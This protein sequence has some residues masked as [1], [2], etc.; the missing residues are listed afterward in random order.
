MATKLVTLVL[1]SSMEVDENQDLQELARSIKEH[2]LGPENMVSITKV[3]IRTTTAGR[4]NK[5]LS[6]LQFAHREAKKHHRPGGQQQPKGTQPY[7]HVLPDKPAFVPIPTPESTQAKVDAE[8]TNI[9]KAVRTEEKK[10]PSVKALSSS[11]IDKFRAKKQINGKEVN[12][13]G[14]P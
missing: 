9:L 10:V 14:N 13:E 3:S 7:V 8:V 12:H 2:G 6:K 4:L 1:R 5:P 11:A